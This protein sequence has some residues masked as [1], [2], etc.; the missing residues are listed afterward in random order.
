[1][2]GAEKEKNMP[3]KGSLW[4]GVVRTRQS[5][6]DGVSIY[7][8]SPHATEHW[9]VVVG[10]RGLVSAHV[11]AVVRFLNGNDITGKKSVSEEENEAR[12]VKESHYLLRLCMIRDGWDFSDP[13]NL[14][15]LPGPEDLRS[16]S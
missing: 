12:L 5:V 14:P 2:I 15:H 11:S 6:F 4:R 13:P 8:D 7:Y 16:G 9:R 10:M 1:L 3:G